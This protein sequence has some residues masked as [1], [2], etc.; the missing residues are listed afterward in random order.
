MPKKKR[1]LSEIEM[2]EIIAAKANKFMGNMITAYG[3]DTTGMLV[4]QMY[5]SLLLS[6]KINEKE[7]E[8]IFSGMHERY[9][10][11][12]KQIRRIQSFLN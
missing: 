9:N 4:E 3:F 1:K 5:F 12:L 11:T 7:S 8:D 10:D 6:A 2:K